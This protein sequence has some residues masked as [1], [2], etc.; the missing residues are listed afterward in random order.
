MRR[1]ERRNR[2]WIF[3]GNAPRGVANLVY[4][5]V[6]SHDAPYVKGRLS[7]RAAEQ[8]KEDPGS[9]AI[10]PGLIE[11]AMLDLFDDFF[12][13]APSVEVE[14]AGDHSGVRKDPQERD[15]S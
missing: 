3:F 6:R 12:A 8:I 11:Q 13:L 14:V 9:D 15:T 1:V 5:I 10:L 2:S 7:R 4:A